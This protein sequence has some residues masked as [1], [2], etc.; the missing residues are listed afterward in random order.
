MLSVCS[1]VSSSDSLWQI[2][3]DDDD[4]FMGLMND[5]FPGLDLPRKQDLNFEAVESSPRV[6]FFSSF[7][8]ERD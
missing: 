4:I 5:L 2:V 8:R 7:F 3:T 1:F 6:A